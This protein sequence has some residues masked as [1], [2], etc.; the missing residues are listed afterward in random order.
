MKKIIAIVMAAMLLI[1]VSAAMAEPL[2]GGWNVP[3]SNEI[4]EE[5]KAIFDKAVEKL[6]GVNYEPVAY[7]ASQ[8]VAGMN[9]CF[10]CKAT[11]VAPDAVPAFK[12][13]YIYEDLEGN[14]TVSSIADLNI[15]L[16]QEGRIADS[17][18]KNTRGLLHN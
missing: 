13:V 8:V 9:H 2:M 15:A 10:L 16:L 12:L 5:Q 18:P 14:A 1:S 4:T 11:V 17:R 3:E 7:L 6:L